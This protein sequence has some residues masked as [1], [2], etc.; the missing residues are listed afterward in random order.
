[1][2]EI[3]H[4]I[5]AHRPNYVQLSCLASQPD[6]GYWGPGGAGETKQVVWESH[7]VNQSF[8]GGHLESIWE[9]PAFLFFFLIDMRGVCGGRVNITSK[10]VGWGGRSQ[11]E[12]NSI[13]EDMEQHIYFSLLALFSFFHA[14]VLFVKMKVGKSGSVSQSKILNVSC[15]FIFQRQSKSQANPYG[16]YSSSLWQSMPIF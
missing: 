2:F 12:C 9:F 4:N 7:S 3:S 8:R 13:R 6:R 11:S 10:W 14:F 1:M 5:S 16:V 15:A